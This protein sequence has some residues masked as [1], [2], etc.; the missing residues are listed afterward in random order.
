MKIYIVRHGETDSNKNRK[1]M[2]QRMNDPLN[3]EGIEQIKKLSE[4]IDTDFDVIFSSPL[5]RAKQSAQILAERIGASVIEKQELMERDFGN[6]SGKTWDEMI[7]K[8]GEE[9]ID[10]K[11]ED[12]EQN[13]DYRPYGGECVADVKERFLKFVEEL[14]KEYADKKVLIVAHGGILKLAHFLF[15]EIKVEHVQNA[16]ICEFDI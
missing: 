9:A 1:L 4:E 3:A 13:Y 14:K 7:E 15:S 12:F 5:V 16:S 11:K 10:L 6:F 2:G 8:L